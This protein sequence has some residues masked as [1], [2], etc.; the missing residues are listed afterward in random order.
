MMG[1]TS[2][3]LIVKTSAIGDI[4]QTMAVLEY[5][6][7]R[8]PECRVDWVVEKGNYHL[9]RSHPLVRHVFV[10]D[11]KKWRK[12][13][14]SIETWKEVS[15]FWK[16]IRQ[17]Q[18]DALF[19]LQS[20]TKSSFVTA[21]AKA[22][23]KVG[24]GFSS[25]HEKP[26]L[27]FTNH[28]IDVN[29]KQNVRLRYLDV[30]K[31][32]F[33]DS[34]EFIPEGRQLFLN[35]DEQARLEEVLQPFSSKGT[36][37]VMVCFGS[38]WTNKSMREDALILFLEG[39]QEATGA[40]FLFVFGDPN[41]EIVA[42]RLHGI[43][44]EGQIVGRMSIPLWQS[45]MCH[46]DAVIAMDSAAL[47]LCGTTRTPSF[48]IFG[49]SSSSVFKPLGDHHCAVQGKCPYGKTFVQRCP[50]LR[51]CSTGACIKDL[52]VNELLQHF[53][54]FWERVENLKNSLC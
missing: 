26:N 24:F 47:H 4:I 21:F 6:H 45:L 53:A 7:K 40:R 41:E 20:N 54:H 30:V 18:Y 8:M 36:P 42:K 39:V 13:P 2:S 5:L 27:L 50:R 11:T 22:E 33:D 10:I 46:M 19:D 43:F 14:M 29:L 34:S 49:A 32:F 23:K 31:G 16:T 52:S 38:R 25:V 15:S 48:S 35:A 37:L 1:R 3:F 51:T 17:Y 9:V 44:P 28:K 12:S